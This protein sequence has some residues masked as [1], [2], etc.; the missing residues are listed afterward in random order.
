MRLVQVTIPAGKKETV[1]SVLDDEGIDYV[2]TDETSGRKYTGVVYFPLPTSAVEPILGRLR[3]VG[4]NDHAYTVVLSAETVVSRQFEQLEAEYAADEETDDRIAR[5][6]LKARADDL[7][8]TWPTY[9]VMT[10]VSAIIATAGLLLDSPATVVGSMVIAPLI[11]PAMAAAVGSVVDDDEL[12]SRGIRMQVVGMALAV[13][14]AA[15]FAKAIDLLNFIP[16]AFDPTSIGQIRERLNPD[17]LSLAVALGSGVAGAVALTTGVSTALVGVMIAV[18]L[19]PPAATVG[20]GIAYGDPSMVL[21][22]GIL[23]V[24]NG[25]SINLAALLVLWYSGYRPERFFREADARSATIRRVAFIVAVIALLSVFLGGVTY[26]SYQ[27]ANTENAVE[28]AVGEV[29]DADGP[30]GARYAEMSVFDLE[31]EFVAEDPVFLLHD[32]E[33]VV[34]TVGIPPDASTNGLAT[35]L[36]RQV[37]EASGDPSVEVQVRYVEFERT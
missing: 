23:A 31:V 16:A 17:F 20:I 25:L 13:V 4:L 34:V 22:S 7:A 8:S 24:V 27:T 21:S 5:E 12:F 28:T 2:L 37:V 9:T 3:E 33:R 10:A 15:V 35:A 19:V 26:D 18:A 30:Y 14:A 29:F 6:E 36:D 1:L 32:P 11:G